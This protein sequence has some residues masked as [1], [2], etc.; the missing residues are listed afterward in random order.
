ML[1]AAEDRATV[2]ARAFRHIDGEMLV[3][4][5]NFIARKAEW[6]AA[7]VAVLALVSVSLFEQ[8]VAQAQQAPPDPTSYIPEVRVATAASVPIATA[9]SYF[10]GIAPSSDT[11][12]SQPGTCDANAAGR[13]MYIRELA[14]ALPQDADEIFKYVHDNVSYQPTFGLKKGAV[15]AILDGDG[16]AADQAQLLV[17]LLRANGFCARYVFGTAEATLSQTQTWLGVEDLASGERVLADGGI[18]VERTSAT[19]KFAHVWVELYGASGATKYDPAFKRRAA[20][21]AALD[22]AAA[23]GLTGA[24]LRTAL[25]GTGDV[26]NNRVYSSVN[27]LDSHLTVKA[28]ALTKLLYVNEAPAGGLPV[29]LQGI[30]FA[31]KSFEQILGVGE[32]LPYGATTVTQAMRTPLAYP[33]QHQNW[34]EVPS[35]FKAIVT[36]RVGMMGGG[37][38]P[39]VQWSISETMPLDIAANSHLEV[40]T[41]FQN[42]A[43]SSHSLKLYRDDVLLAQTTE[44]GAGHE[45]GS[46]YASVGIDLP[47]A[48]SV[49]GIQGTYGD[50]GFIG[51]IDALSFTTIF[52]TAGRTSPRRLSERGRL[53]VTNSADLF[54]NVLL[55]GNPAADNLMCRIPPEP[56]TSRTI[57]VKVCE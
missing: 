38:S 1:R 54:R 3:K 25:A 52:A 48:A 5:L 41:P 28:Q 9:V 15:G 13:S 56:M 36:V 27:G 45:F 18:P 55:V 40:R 23:V 20:S 24:G 10:N 14:K 7:A 39:Q 34:Y 43:T 31:S 35:R 42:A 33:S 46:W 19:L 37:T 29:A 17:E 22:L 11:A 16:T 8:Q 4:I 44:L 6:F 30:D 53:P 49:S 51:A 57:Y 12:L 47:Y 26:N 21:S 50:S 32:V 2:E